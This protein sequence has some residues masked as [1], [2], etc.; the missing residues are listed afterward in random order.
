[1]VLC[2]IYKK[3]SKMSYLK[4][5]IIAAV[6]ITTIEFFVGFIFNIVLKQNIWNYSNMPLNIYGQICLIYSFLW[7]FLGLFIDYLVNYK[8]TTKTNDKPS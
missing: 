6:V 7:G 2:K 3:H 4:K 8:H 5:Y 1:M